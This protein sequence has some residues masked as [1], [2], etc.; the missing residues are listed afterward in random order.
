M[1][2][3]SRVTHKGS[4]AGILA[5]LYT[6]LLWIGLYPVTAMYKQPY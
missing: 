2:M 3:P 6:L 1:N 4:H 5:L